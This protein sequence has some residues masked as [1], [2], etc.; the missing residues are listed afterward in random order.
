MVVKN[1][2]SSSF[3]RNGPLINSFEFYQFDTYGDDGT[4]E[5]RLNPSTVEFLSLVFMCVWSEVL[6]L[7]LFEK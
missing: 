3:H 7:L 4:S 5:A 1:V 2:I 6:H